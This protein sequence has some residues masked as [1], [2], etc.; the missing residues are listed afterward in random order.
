MIFSK[1]LPNEYTSDLKSILGRLLIYSF[2]EYTRV[3][4][5]Q[6]TL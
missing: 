4:P 1:V 6:N 2:E 3:Y 5:L